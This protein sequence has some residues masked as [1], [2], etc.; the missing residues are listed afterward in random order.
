MFVL[1][2][3]KE[4][5]VLMASLELREVLA[6]LETLDTRALLGHLDHP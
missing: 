4:H 1:R 6:N 3:R 5:Q 2:E